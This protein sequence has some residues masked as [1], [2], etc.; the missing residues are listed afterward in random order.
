MA[1]VPSLPKLPRVRAGPGPVV[2]WIGLAGCLALFA[3][4]PVWALITGCAVLALL[5]TGRWMM[6]RYKP[7]L[8]QT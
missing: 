6:L 2:S 3:S 8:T 4:L 7:T 1:Q 5:V